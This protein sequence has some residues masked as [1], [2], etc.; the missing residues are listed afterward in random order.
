[1]LCILSWKLSPGVQEAVAVLIYVILGMSV[2]WTL[3][4][5]APLVV[6]KVNNATGVIL[7][8]ALIMHCWCLCRRGIPL[9]PTVRFMVA[10]P[11][12][13]GWSVTQCGMRSLQVQHIQSAALFKTFCFGA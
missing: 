4:Y 12:F 2:C 9:A 1:L 11:L 13:L 7:T 3:L 6:Q 5:P 8:V 10:A